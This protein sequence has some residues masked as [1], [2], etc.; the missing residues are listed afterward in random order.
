MQWHSY[1]VQGI[2]KKK[3]ITL[4]ASSPIT[5]FQ[6]FKFQNHAYGIQFHIEI[7][8]NTVSQWACVP[9]YETALEESLG[10]G[11]LFK[12]DK[13]AQENM[14]NMNFNAENLYNNFKKLL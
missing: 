7:K 10:K 9:E 1:E 4:L 5:K 13:I 12:F 2:E 6:I 11:A 8:S 3:D 14:Q